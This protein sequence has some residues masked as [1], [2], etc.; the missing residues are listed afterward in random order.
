M[1]KAGDVGVDAACGASQVDEEELQAIARAAAFV[2]HQ[3]LTEE[4]NRPKL[5]PQIKFTVPAKHAMGTKPPVIFI[6]PG[7]CLDADRRLVVFKERT[8]RQGVHCYMDSVLQKHPEGRY[9]KHV[10]AQWDK[11]SIK[12]EPMPKDARSFVARAAYDGVMLSK[13]MISQPEHGRWTP[14][15]LPDLDFFG[16]VPLGESGPKSTQ[17]LIA[18]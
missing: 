18:S 16:Y 14:D 4:T 9:A 7:T 3:E 17:T 5:P 1:Q 12:Y 10:R 6:D 8:L 15:Q 11:A 13:H 2:R